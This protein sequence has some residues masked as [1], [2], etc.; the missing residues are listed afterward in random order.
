L[1]RRLIEV[2]NEVE[3]SIEN[4]GGQKYSIM[5]AGYRW[6][7]NGDVL[8]N[9]EVRTKAL[10]SLY[11]SSGVLNNLLSEYSGVGINGTQCGSAHRSLDDGTDF[12]LGAASP[13]LSHIAYGTDAPRYLR[14]IGVPM[15]LTRFAISA[16]VYADS[17]HI[18]QLLSDEQAKS[19]GKPETN[20]KTPEE[21]ASDSGEKANKPSRAP[22]EF[23]ELVPMPFR[24]NAKLR[25]AVASAVLLFGY[26]S[27]E[28]SAMSVSKP[29]WTALQEQSGAFRGKEPDSL[30][31]LDDFLTRVKSFADNEELPDAEHVSEYVE[32]VLL[33]HCLRLCIMGNGPSTR[34]ARGSKGEYDTAFGISQYPEPSKEVQSPL[35]DPCLPLEEQSLEAVAYASAMLRRA[36]LMRAAVHL[37]SGGVPVDQ[38]DNVAR[39][40]FMCKNLDGLPLWW[41]PWVHDVALLVHAASH[42]LFAIVRDR[43]TDAWDSVFCQ[44]SIVQSMYSTFVTV[45]NVLPKA[46]VEKSAPDDTSDWIDLHA[47]EFPTA[48]VIERRL[49]FLCNQATFTLSGELRYDNLPMFDHGGWPRA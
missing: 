20:S 10:S 9:R 37:V 19:Y 27:K 49:A 38:L 8:T 17:G 21:K 34:N 36:R 2:L 11:P 14:A 29:L 30:F 43:E 12:A 6:E 48:N 28:T 35:P 46:I 40:S 39:S 47:A 33:P 15:N 41:C 5:E 24:V 22:V 18:Q 13:E 26:T 16:L 44:K 45:E 32:K 1:N 7:A 25:A 31:S 42:G 23:A 4:N 3:A